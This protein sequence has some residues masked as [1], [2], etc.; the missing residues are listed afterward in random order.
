MSQGEREK[1]LKLYSV[2]QLGFPSPPTHSLKILTQELYMQAAM[3]LPNMGWAHWTLEI[4]D[5]CGWRWVWQ[6]HLSSFFSQIFIIPSAE[7]EAMRCP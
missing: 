4:N 2:S 1:V 5:V 7:Q 6:T 3:M